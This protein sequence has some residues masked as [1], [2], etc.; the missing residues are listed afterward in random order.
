MVRKGEGRKYES[1][2][3]L[4][5]W[6]GANGTSPTDGCHEGELALTEACR[7]SLKLHLERIVRTKTKKNQHAACETEQT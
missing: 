2:H 7:N 5:I 4:R 6:G 3:A 1:F